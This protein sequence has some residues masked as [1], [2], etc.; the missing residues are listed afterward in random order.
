MNGIRRGRGIPTTV[1]AKDGHRAGTCWTATS[2][3]RHPRCRV[4]DFTYCRT[5]AG[6]LY[7]AFVWTSSPSGPWDGA[8]TDGRT[9]L[10]LTALRIASWDRDRWAPG[11][12]QRTAATTPTR[13]RRVR[14]V[15]RRARTRGKLPRR[16]GP[17]RGSRECPDGNRHRLLKTERIATTVFLDG[18]YRALA[19]VE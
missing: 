19:A 1:P 6:F 10:V 13:A 11:R 7:V 15:G 9:D 16:S 12:A 17:L 4:A 18:P 8:A 5:W 14:S 3:Q 2:P